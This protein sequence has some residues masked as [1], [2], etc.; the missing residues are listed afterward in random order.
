VS[1]NPLV[2]WVF[3]DGRLIPWLTVG[4][5]LSFGI[6]SSKDWYW[7]AVVTSLCFRGRFFNF[8]GWFPD[9][10]VLRA[11][12]LPDDVLYRFPH[13]LSGG[14]KMRVALLRAFMKSPELLFLDE[15]FSSLDPDIALQLRELLKSQFSQSAWVIVTH[16]FEEAL[17][18]SEEIWLLSETGGLKVLQT[19]SQTVNGLMKEFAQLRNRRRVDSV[20]S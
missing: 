5:N 16:N 15:P 12:A 8:R 19:Q 7:M 3:Q 10:E 18:L 13:Q 1:T 9:H 20:S 14:E 11:F 2:G 17:E 4:E 6:S